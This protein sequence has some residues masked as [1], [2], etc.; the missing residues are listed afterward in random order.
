MKPFFAILLLLLFIAIA[1]Y[2]YAKK[3][4]R[5]LL[6]E[7]QV[8][9]WKVYHIKEHHFS[10]GT[11]HYFEV[12]LGSRKLVLP[13]ELTGGSREVSRFIAAGAHNSGE[14]NY[15]AVMIVCEGSVKNER[16]FEER[17]QMSLMVRAI[18]TNGNKLEVNNLCNGKTATLTLE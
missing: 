12:Y 5:K 10:I 11:N 3:Q 14:T 18:G 2:A 1:V 4:S 13:K 16:G 15:D 9:H 7:N 17:Q 8:Y 6:T